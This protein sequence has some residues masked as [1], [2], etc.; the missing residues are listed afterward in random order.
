M[1][2]VY[3]INMILTRGDFKLFVSAAAN[4]CN[5]QPR[6]FVYL[7]TS[8]GTSEVAALKN[9]R[10]ITIPGCNFAGKVCHSPDVLLLPVSALA[11]KI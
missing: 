7:Q 8:G 6:V 10:D 9:G 11:A 4:E 1:A 3:T 2:D 5:S